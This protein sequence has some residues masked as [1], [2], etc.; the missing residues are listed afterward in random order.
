MPKSIN[1]AFFKQD[2][3]VEREV[4]KALKAVAG[5]KVIA[6]DIAFLTSEQQAEFACI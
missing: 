1:L 3:L 2:N 5:L 6:I 4:L